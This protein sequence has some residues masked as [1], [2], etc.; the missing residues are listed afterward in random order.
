MAQTNKPHS[1]HRFMSKMGHH[2]WRILV[3]VML[4]AGGIW[5][6]AEIAGAVVAGETRAIDE[7]LLLALREPTD[8]SNPLG[9]RWFEEM[10]RDFTSLGGTGILVLIVMT[11]GGYL[12]MLKRYKRLIVLLTAVIGGMLL[13]PLLKGIFDRPRPDLILEGSYAL[14]ASFPSGHAL[15]SAATYLTLGALLAQIQTRFRLK[16]FFILV[17]VLIMFIVGFSRLYLGV[18]WPSDVLAGWTI[19]SMWAL[20][21]WAAAHWLQEHDTP[22]SE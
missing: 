19:G 5:F 6:L 13:S 7:M 12:F 1:F 2:E 11:V 3:A 18:H 17:S 10:V 20:L 8:V 9:P 14:N 4:I 21:C 16:A 15:L 22:L